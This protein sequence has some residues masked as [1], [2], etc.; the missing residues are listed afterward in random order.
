MMGMIWNNKAKYDEYFRIPGWYISGDSA[1]MDEDGYYW[2]QGRIDDV[3]NSSG[4]R[5]GPFEVESKLVEHPAVAEAGVI[6]KPDVLRGEIIKAFISLREGYTAT[7][8][9]KEEIAAF[10]KAGLS[11]HAAPGRSNLRR[12]CPRPAPAKLYAGC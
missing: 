9:L 3:I 12:S 1:Y 2:F 7:P 4:E 8:E 6:G 10:V 5:I 11:A